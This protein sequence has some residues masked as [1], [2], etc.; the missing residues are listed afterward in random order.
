MTG[1]IFDIQRFAIH[2][3]P[4]IR[5]TVFFKGCSARCEWCHNPES[6]SITPQLQ[7]YEDRCVSCG[8]CVN[9]CPQGAHVM[10]DRT[11]TQ[12]GTEAIRKGHFF[13]RRRCIACG[14]CSGECFS[15][16]LVIC[17]REM[18][19]E[20]VLRQVL[21]DKP[22]YDESGGGVTLSGGEPVLQD[23]FC[24]A[25]LKSLKNVSLH[26]TV[27][28]AGFYSFEKLDRLLPYLDVVMY[29]IKGLSQDIFQNHIHASSSLALDNLKRLDERGIPIIV[30]TPC[31]KG[32]N[33]DAGEIEAIARMLSSL[34]HLRYYS[35]IPYHGLAK[36]KYDVLGQEFK[37]YEAPSKEH[38]EML[39]RLAAR[40]VTVWN[41][42]KG[43]VQHAKD[44]GLA[45]EQG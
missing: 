11:Q 8:N 31:V 21:D 12:G 2:D 13:D 44:T 28:T 27:Q 15:N 5:S 41:T 40:F 23:D 30:R 14:L 42:E 20:D 25:L 39:E 22:Y 45:G 9:L 36:I 4:G 38:M 19:V 34:K 43:I 37:R 35:L 24:E 26:T 29:D 32:L 33:D 16:A 17:G 6:L 18:N 3:G 1:V 7:Y 10:R